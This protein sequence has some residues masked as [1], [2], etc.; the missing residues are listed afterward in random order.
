MEIEFGSTSLSQVLKFEAS[1][2]L[3]GLDPTTFSKGS[4]TCYIKLSQVKLMRGKE[5]IV[6]VTRMKKWTDPRQRI[7]NPN[8]SGEET[9]LE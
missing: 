5:E 7:L 3:S 8:E 6:H 9:E 1:L 4:M 2:S